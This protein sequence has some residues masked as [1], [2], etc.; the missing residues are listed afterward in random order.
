MTILLSLSA[1]W[2][3]L[4]YFFF[5]FIH[6]NKIYFFIIAAIIGAISLTQEVNIIN[7]GYVGFSFFLLVMFTGVI[8]KGRLKKSLIATRAEMAILGFIFIAV[9]GVKFLAF[10]IDFNFL[11]SGPLY[12]YLGIISLVI[13]APLFITSFMFIRKKMN[14]KNWKKLHKLSYLFYLSIGL[15]LILIQN[16]RIIFYI[17]IFG[18][19]F[20]LKIW[21]LIEAKTKKAPA[22]KVITTS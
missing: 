8:D 3:V 9:H 21:T 14:G 5:K 2:I 20:V 18:L 1:L 22:K 7:L 10:S 17:G 12:F 19:Y 16:D 6:K 13:A 15:H 4:N 11:F